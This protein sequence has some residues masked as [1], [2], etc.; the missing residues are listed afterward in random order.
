MGESSPVMKH[1]A[2]QSPLDQQG[3]AHRQCYE[4]RATCSGPPI[5]AANL[6]LVFCPQELSEHDQSV[7]QH[8]VSC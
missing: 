7:Q 4:V 8:H 3:L 6:S 2:E 1:L 5:S